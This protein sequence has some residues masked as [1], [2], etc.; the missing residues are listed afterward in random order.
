VISA[1]SGAGLLAI[2]DVLRLAGTATEFAA[3]VLLAGW[4]LAADAV[5]AASA[6]LGLLP[7]AARCPGDETSA[8]QG[9]AGGTDVERDRERWQ[10]TLLELGVLPCLRR[11]LPGALFL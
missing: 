9:S 10:H 6:G 3:S 8:E 4:V 5:M 2:G 7:R 1:V 11:R